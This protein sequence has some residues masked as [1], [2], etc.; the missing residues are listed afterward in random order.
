MQDNNKLIY[1]KIHGYIKVDKIS[2]SIIDTYE[3]QRLRNIYQAGVLHYVFPCANNNR[4]EHS[5]GTYFLAKKMITNL[6]HNQPELN[7]NDKLILCVGLAGLCHDLGHAMFSHL[8]DNY[9][10]YKNTNINKK[11][12]LFEHENRSIQLLVYI[13]KKYNLNIDDMMVRIIGDLIN[14][15]NANYELWDDEYKVGKWIFEIVSNDY[16]HLDVDK[17]DYLA[18]DTYSIGLNYGVDSSRLIEQAR[19]IEIYGSS[20]IYYPLQT[21]DDIRNI[22]FTRYRLHKNIYNHKAVKGIELIIIEILKELD[23][24]RNISE[25]IFDMEKF[26]KL[27]DNMI[28]YEENEKIKK[29]IEKLIKRDFPKMEY[30]KINSDNFENI[31]NDN[32]VK[33]KIGLVNKKENPL[34]KVPFYSLKDGLP[35]KF[36]IKNYGN[37]LKENHLEYITRIYK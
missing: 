10:I 35:K 32:V 17:F 26:I 37:Y 19:V 8:F 33:I 23:R 3:F 30:E 34:L 7:I 20:H 29:L 9:I 18:R 16:C 21:S 12:K 28:F 13:I 14:P 22:F 1:D 5:L 2:L 24:T 36:D 31:E 25:W 6:K 4:F 27:Q 11:N 15:K